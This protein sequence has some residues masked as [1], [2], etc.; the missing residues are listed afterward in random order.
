[1]EF[2][3]AGDKITK[4]EEFVDSGFARDYLAKVIEWQ[5]QKETTPTSN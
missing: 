1:M 2:N 3:D 5:N 4:I